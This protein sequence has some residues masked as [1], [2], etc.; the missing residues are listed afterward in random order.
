MAQVFNKSS[1][2]VTIAGESHPPFE[3]YKLETLREERLL[4]TTRQ[5][6]IT[7]GSFSYPSV[8]KLLDLDKLNELLCNT[9]TSEDHFVIVVDPTLASAVRREFD[10]LSAKVEVQAQFL[11]QFAGFGP[12]ASKGLTAK[13][14]SDLLT[15]EEQ[16]A[17]DSMLCAVLERIIWV[18]ETDSTGFS[19]VNFT[20]EV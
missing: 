11:E 20:P 5:Q 7:V 15:I 17:I 8:A 13:Q 6:P 1:A 18:D 14:R 19:G 16:L 12:T 4:G 9:R 3:T 10:R 2:T